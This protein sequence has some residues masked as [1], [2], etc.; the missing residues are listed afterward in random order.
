MDGWLTNRN[1]LASS[2]NIPGGDEN[3]G[4]ITLKY[5]DPDIGLRANL[6]GTV[7]SEFLNANSASMEQGLCTL[8][9]YQK[10]GP[11]IG[12]Y[13]DC[14]ADNIAVGAPDP[15]PYRPDLTYPPGSPN[16]LIGQPSP[17]ANRGHG[18][19]AFVKGNQVSLDINYD[20]VPGLTITSLSGLSYVLA[21]QGTA[22]PLGHNSPL[23]GIYELGGRDAHRDFSEELRVTSNWNGWFNFMAGGLYTHSSFSQVTDQIIPA[24]GLAESNSDVMMTDTWGGFA[25]VLLTPVKDWEIAAGARLTSIDRG[26]TSAHLS[27]NFM[28]PPTLV[29]ELI[30]VIPENLK[31]II[32]TKG[33]PEFTVTY[34]PSDDLTAFASYKQGY[35]APGFN[36]NT[37][38]VTY[39]PTILT[40]FGPENVSGVEGGVKAQLFDHHAA[41]TVSSYRYEYR[42]LQVSFSNQVTR[43][44]QTANA[45]KAIVEGAELAAVVNP[46]GTRNLTLKASVNINDT[47]YDSFTRAVCYGGQTVAEGCVGGV[48]NLSGQRTELAPLWSGQ[49][50]ADYV[51]P[52][53]SSYS[54]AL[55]FNVNYSSAY[56]AETGHNPNGLQASYATIDCALRFGKLDGPWEIALLGRNLT[57]R[58]IMVGG[59]DS[60]QV[61][62]GVTA[63]MN[64]LLARPLQLMLQVTARSK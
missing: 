58:Y 23:L 17:L 25:Q 29:G 57:N 1:P 8:S 21:Q 59:I 9:Y 45:A 14:K 32:Q 10:N 12:N 26:M 34:R 33:T 44:V 60:G 15:L 27:N 35:K 37:S 28:L 50:G 2:H 31:R 20:P 41:V 53:T 61:I 40:P 64:A 47:H 36:F 13:D 56:Y 62:P 54:G 55:N 6:K 42:G 63:D 39:S 19:Y 52:V 4:R 51:F 38:A 3:S 16:F 5:D 30:G 24:F 18:L 49:V 7:V 46:P 22:L 48:Q 43:I 11:Y